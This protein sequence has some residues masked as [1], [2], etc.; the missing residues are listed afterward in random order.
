MF[1]FTSRLRYGRYV[2]GNRGSSATLAKNRRRRF[3]VSGAGRFF[4]DWS[5]S[6]S[7]KSIS[8]L[9]VL[10]LLF[11]PIGIIIWACMYAR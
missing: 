11:G 9:V 4:L 6:M 5:V 2:L 8:D 1:N 7:G 10:S 3:P